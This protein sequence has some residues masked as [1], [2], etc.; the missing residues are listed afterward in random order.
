MYITIIATDLRYV[1]ER[2]LVCYDD[3]FVLKC[4]NLLDINTE[5]R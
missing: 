4:I 5:L 2:V 3:P 1:Q